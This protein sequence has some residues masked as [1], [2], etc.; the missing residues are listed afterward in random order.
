MKKGDISVNEFTEM[1][2]YLEPHPAL[3]ERLHRWRKPYTSEK[4]HMCLWFGSQETTGSGNYTRSAPNSSARITYDRL[5][6]P[7]AMLWIAE[8]LGEG[9]DR[10]HAAAQAARVAEKK[11]WRDRG[12]GF[13]EVIPFDRI[14][15]LYQHPERWIYDKQLASYMRFGDDGYPIP[16][17]NAF[18]RVV[19]K[20]LR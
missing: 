4:A 6:C 13:R 17:K 2:L 1:L 7:G 15:Q 8:V 11:N 3:T 16:T 20:Q 14:Y 9:P 19:N 10:L 12:N 5:L 18:W